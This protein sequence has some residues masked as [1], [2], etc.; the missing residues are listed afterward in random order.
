MSNNPFFIFNIIHLKHV[1][2]NIIEVKPFEEELNIIREV[3]NDYELRIRKIKKEKEKIINNFIFKV[4]ELLNNYQEY[5]YELN[6][7]KGSRN[8]ININSNNS[9]DISNSNSNS[10]KPSLNLKEKDE[11]CNGSNSLKASSLKQQSNIF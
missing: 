1:K 8:N 2:N 5:I 10:N 4:N 3:I 9:N 6:S 7:S 11:S